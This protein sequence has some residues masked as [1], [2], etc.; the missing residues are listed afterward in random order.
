MA[1]RYRFEFA[2]GTVLLALW[3]AIWFWQNPGAAGRLDAQD[4]ARYMAAL[5]QLPL[6]PEERE[7]TLQRARA[8]MQSDDG[9]PVYMLNLM[10]YYPELR[11]YAGS[12]DFHGTPQQSNAIYE[13]AVMPLLLKVG[14]FPLYAGRAQGPNLF[15]HRDELDDWSRVLVVRYP[16]RRAFF[17]LLCN[18]AYREVAPYKLMALRLVLTPG[19]VE[20]AIP[21]LSWL[22][23][24]LL[25][26]VFLAVGWG[27]AVRRPRAA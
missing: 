3:A 24:G 8:W 4:V 12:L 16:S 23:G 9:K 13:N 21:E 14:G 11:R 5:E 19:S 22:A 7:A 20:V 15:E 18:P 27:R 25:L 1:K 10:R 6:P 26:I 17:D 2:L